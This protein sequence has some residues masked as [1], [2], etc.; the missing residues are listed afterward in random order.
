M[1][2]TIHKYAGTDHGCVQ[3]VSYMPNMV[4]VGG[5]GLMRRRADTACSSSFNP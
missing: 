1:V 2:V 4:I 5:S 3:N